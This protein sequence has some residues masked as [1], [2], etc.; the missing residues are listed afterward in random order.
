MD[1]TIESELLLGVGPSIYCFTSSVILL[2]LLSFINGMQ[3]AISTIM[4]F[5]KEK[6]SHSR[7]TLN[8]RMNYACVS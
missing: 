5:K 4:T 7:L 3:S 6:E 1:K 8:D 2:V